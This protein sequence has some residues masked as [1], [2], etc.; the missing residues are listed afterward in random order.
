[1]PP[2]Y[3]IHYSESYEIPLTRYYQGP[4]LS[5][6]NIYYDSDVLQPPV[7][8]DRFTPINAMEW[9]GELPLTDEKD[10]EGISFLKQDEDGHT[11]LYF[12]NSHL[13][14]KIG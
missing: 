10:V 8:E 4:D 9:V 5:I 1:M 11:F 13:E 7:P 3:A 6:S 2:Y 12:L 14:L